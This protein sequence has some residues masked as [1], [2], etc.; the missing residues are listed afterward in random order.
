MKTQLKKQVLLLSVAAGAAGLT[1]WSCLA[2]ET[3]DPSAVQAATRAPSLEDQL[4]GLNIPENYAP[5][6]VANEKLY[7]VQ[8]RFLRLR[9]VSE[10][11]TGFARN[12]TV[13]SYL[14]S[15]QIDLSYRYHLDD[16][17][18]L[19]A[20][21]SAVFNGRSTAGDRLLEMNGLVPD[22][23]YVKYRADLTASMNAFYGKIRVSMDRVFY[24]DQYITLGPA[25]IN[26]DTG[27]SVAG[28]AGAGFAFWWDKKASV[29]IGVKDYFYNAKKALSSGFVN[30][31][32]GFVDVG[33]LLGG[34]RS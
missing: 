7:A 23:A 8:N 9:G 32:V 13:D 26:M 27:T 33:I 2:A 22:A 16:R 4:E 6:S 11:S 25:L 12:F 28:V 30:D 3:P 17:W 19:T 15:N 20:A 1:A 21:G 18:S 14:V 29:R 24:F 5:A 10:L 31:V 34:D